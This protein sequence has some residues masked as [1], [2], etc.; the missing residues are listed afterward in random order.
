MPEASVERK[1]TSYLPVSSVF[2]FIGLRFCWMSAEET[3]YFAPIHLEHL[4]LVFQLQLTWF[5]CFLDTVCSV[6][7]F[8]RLD[9][10]SITPASSQRCLWGRRH[11]NS[12]RLC[13]T[14]LCLLSGVPFCSCSL[15]LE[16]PSWQGLRKG[17]TLVWCLKTPFANYG[18]CL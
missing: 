12:A 8:P 10:G 3:A 18:C 6:V 16:S 9:S 2:M 14:R 11:M 17:D 5:E 7:S 4:H 13:L 1:N 15:S